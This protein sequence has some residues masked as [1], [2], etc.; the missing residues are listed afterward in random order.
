MLG[1]DLSVWQDSAKKST[2][3]RWLPAAFSLFWRT[4][5]IN[6]GVWGR[7]PRFHFNV[8]DVVFLSVAM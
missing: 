6:P 3:K 2:E 5:A 4:E 8:Q 7:A 1:S